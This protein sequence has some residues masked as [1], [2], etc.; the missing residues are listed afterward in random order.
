[1]YFPSG[2][3]YAQRCADH[4]ESLSGNSTVN[5]K[6]V[7]LENKTRGEYLEKYKKKEY[8]WVYVGLIKF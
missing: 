6:E 1:M 4:L 7:L 8:Q 2:A 5:G 3:N